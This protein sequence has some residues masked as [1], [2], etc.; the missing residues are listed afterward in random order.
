MKSLRPFCILSQNVYTP[1]WSWTKCVSAKPR[2]TYW[3]W[4]FPFWW[5]KHS[6]WLM[7]SYTLDCCLSWGIVVYTEIRYRKIWYCI[8]NRITVIVDFV[9]ATQDSAHAWILLMLCTII[10]LDMTV[11]HV[12]KVHIPIYL[13][14]LTVLYKITS[15]HMGT[16]HS[17][18]RISNS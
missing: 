15:K 6:V 10:T 16:L 17:Y 13:F 5:K 4:L 8:Q 14:L 12:H 3:K 9:E 2:T 1:E 11:V 18:A 7:M